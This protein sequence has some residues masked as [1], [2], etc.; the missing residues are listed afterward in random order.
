WNTTKIIAGRTERQFWLENFHSKTFFTQA[1]DNLY[2]A[3]I[4]VNSR[5]A[6]AK[7]VEIVAA[8]KKT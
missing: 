6:V 4:F 2:A 1:H 5:L 3:T 8:F 7:S